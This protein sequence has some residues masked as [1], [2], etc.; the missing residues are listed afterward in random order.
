MQDAITLEK[1][2]VPSVVLVTQPFDSQARSM[3]NIMGLPGYEYALIDHPMGSLTSDEVME[4]AKSALP[5]VVRQ[6]IA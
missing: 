6:L 4:R 1:R 2:G 5:Q 3:A